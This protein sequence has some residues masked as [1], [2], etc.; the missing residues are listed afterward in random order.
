MTQHDLLYT[1]TDTVHQ[2][3]S[4]KCTHVHTQYMD[5]TLSQTPVLY[6]SPVSVILDGFMVVFFTGFFEI[7]IVAVSQTP[8]RFFEFV[9]QSKNSRCL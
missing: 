7:V 3:F 2:L 5:S 6:I 1:C 8:E 9:W 4:N